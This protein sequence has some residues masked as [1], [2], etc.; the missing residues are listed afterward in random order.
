MLELSWTSFKTSETDGGSANLHA[1]IILPS[2][3][4]DTDK[5]IIEENPGITVACEFINIGTVTLTPADTTLSASKD[6][7]VPFPSGSFL[8]YPVDEYAMKQWRFSASPPPQT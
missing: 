2:Y 4:R 3:L 5:S 8:F 1:T 6:F 7:T